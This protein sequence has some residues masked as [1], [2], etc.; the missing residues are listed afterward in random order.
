MLNLL[1]IDFG[2]EISSKTCFKSD[3]DHVCVCMCCMCVLSCARLFVKPQTLA[4]QAPL[5][6]GF[7][8][9]EYWSVLPFPPPGDLPDAGINPASLASP[10]L[11][12]G[13]FTTEP[14]HHDNTPLL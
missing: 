8:R 7:S 14:P 2:T 12:G 3:R 1:H 13:F 9:Q 4:R 11:A 10:E 6:M 5:S